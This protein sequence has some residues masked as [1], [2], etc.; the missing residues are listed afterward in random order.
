[1]PTIV[2][3]LIVT[4]GLDAKQFQ[5]TQQELNDS[6]AK[7]K[8]NAQENAKHIEDST[9]KI[10]KALESFGKKFIAFSA[11]IGSAAAF[12]Q[13]IKNT[14][15][16][17][18][19]LGR[20]AANLGTAPQEAGEMADM[21]TRLGG[22]ADDARQALESANQTIQ[23]FKHNGQGLPKALTTMLAITRP[24]QG[25]AGLDLDHGAV[26]FY[27]TLAPILKDM[28]KYDKTWEHSLAG[29]LNIPAA[30]ET[31]MVKYGSD[32]RSKMNENAPLQATNAQIEAAQRLYEEWTKTEQI[33]REIGTNIA[34]W[35]NG[36][37]EKA[38]ELLNTVLERVA[39]QNAAS[40]LSMPA[41][42]LGSGVKSI[43]DMLPSF[44]SS[45]GAAKLFD[46][47]GS[48]LSP[49]GGDMPSSGA[50]PQSGGADSGMFNL[51]SVGIT[52]GGVDVSNGNPFPVRMVAAG[53]AASGGFW[54]KISG[55]FGS[56]FS[57]SS[58]S[59]S[60]ST[61]D[62]AT[63]PNS[64]G[65][66]SGTNGPVGAWW[67]P[68]RIKHAVD[69][70][71]KEGG[72]S[73]AGAAGLVARWAGI[74]ARGGPGS[75]NPRSGAFGIGQWLGSRKN[76]IDGNTDFDAQISHA[77]KELAT[78]EKAAASVLKSAISE[79]DGARGASMFERA[80]GFNSRTGTDNFTGSTPVA[81]VLRTVLGQG[82]IGAGGWKW[83]PPRT[84][85]QKALHFDSST[86]KF[87]WDNPAGAGVAASASAIGSSTSNNNTTQ[88]M[89]VGTISVNAPNATDANGI[90]KEIA[91]AL[92][93]HSWPDQANTG[94]Q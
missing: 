71:E 20:F 46:D 53:D 78:T 68:D 69:R 17:N 43:W 88:S 31:A 34:A 10:G 49:G 33:T 85:P 11:I 45:G 37:L 80:E 52:V 83:G 12:A 94:A 2:D 44:K 22:S 73:E 21:L 89:H 29:E 77:I 28:A 60:G 30:L 48:S 13:F 93:R 39:K 15:D 63:S 19:A 24:G 66:V 14:N 57:G 84:K 79:F 67:T 56:L 72:L 38:V 36:P 76:G 70:L 40:T 91:P 64:S 16:A 18:A 92:A 6:F 4:L 74:E 86:G 23:D 75:K 42:A 82:D 5:K 1:M 26:K 7:T 47:Y 32:F 65:S 27:Q 54:S 8:K 62:S 41:F 55:A 25:M 50:S 3:S 51:G 81:S 61:G 87:E 9:D 90:A 59:S 58:S 35:V